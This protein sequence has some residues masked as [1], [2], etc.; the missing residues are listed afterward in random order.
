MARIINVPGIRY[1]TSVLKC[2][3]GTYKLVGTIPEY[4]D[5]LSFQTSEIAELALQ[6]A[7]DAL[8]AG[9]ADR[10]ARF[11]Q[12]ADSAP[13]E[14]RPGSFHLKKVLVTQDMI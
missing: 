9:H 5:R 8:G 7:Q 11:Y 2:P 3:A 6:E 4:M 12:I 1:Q 13:R 14:Y 10:S